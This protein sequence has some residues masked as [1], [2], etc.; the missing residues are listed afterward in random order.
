M[1]YKKYEVKVESVQRIEFKDHQGAHFATLRV[2]RHEND[3]GPFHIDCEEIHAEIAKFHDMAC[4]KIVEAVLE[5]RA[6][7]RVEWTGRDGCGF[8]ARKEFGQ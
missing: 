1:K 5:M 2:W 8:V 4:R 7:T 3:M 6:V